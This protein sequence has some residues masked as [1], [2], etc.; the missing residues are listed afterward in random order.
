MVGG[1]GGREGGR[2]GSVGPCYMLHHI[3]S[4]RTF[5]GLFSGNLEN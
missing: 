4:P 3:F 5:S 1:G 2:E